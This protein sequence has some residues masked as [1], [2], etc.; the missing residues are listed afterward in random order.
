MA[1]SLFVR[2]QDVIKNTLIDGDIDSDKLIPHIEAAQDV[3]LFNLLGQNLYEHIDG[4]IADNEI[5]NSG[6]E[7]YLNLTTTFIRPMIEQ[8]AAARFLQ[9]ARYTINDKGVFIHSANNATAANY[10]YALLRRSSQARM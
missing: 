7:A 2:P 6:N 4:L 5:R 10:S 9:Y 3:D 1:R 8:Y